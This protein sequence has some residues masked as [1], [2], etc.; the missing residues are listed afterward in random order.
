M[1]PAVHVLIEGFLYGLKFVPQPP[2]ELLHCIVAMPLL[3]HLLFV[4][5][6]TDG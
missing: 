4:K 5:Q 1:N 3:L 6:L 2:P